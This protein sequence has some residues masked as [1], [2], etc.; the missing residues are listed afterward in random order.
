MKSNGIIRR[1]DGLGRI[2][3]PIHMRKEL[4]LFE[5]DNVE[6]LMQ[7]KE[8]VIRKYSSLKGSGEI[9]FKIAEAI[10]KAIGGTILI[11]D[12]EQILSSYGEKR[13]IYKPL[14]NVSSNL[15]IRFEKEF[16]IYLP[17]VLEVI[18]MLFVFASLVLGEMGNYY[19]KFPYWDAMLHTLN[20]FLSAAAGFGLVD[21][22]NE[23][24]RI[25]FKLSPLFLAVVAFCFSMTIGVVWEFFEFVCDVF[26]GMD[27][28]NDTLVNSFSSSFLSGNTNVLVVVDG[29]RSVEVN[30]RTLVTDGYLDI[31]LY[32]TMMDLVV[33]FIGAVVFSVLGYFYV[34][35]RGKHKFALHFIPRRKKRKKGKKHEKKD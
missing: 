31:G 6:L 8:I 14:V 9:Y 20:G 13:N 11:V 21:I 1:I 23:N 12:E 16:D 17:N 26:F 3:I 15:K 10:Y 32:D 5:N 19:I 29:I 2:V 27:L 18:L 22:L 35:N 33:N 25:K 7:D 24:E 4:N 34:K 30:G 28:Q